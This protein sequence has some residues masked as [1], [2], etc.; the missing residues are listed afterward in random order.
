MKLPLREHAKRRIP[1]LLMLLLLLP[2]AATGVADRVIGYSGLGSL[3]QSNR[4]WLEE[5]F[6]RSLHLFGVLSAVK[7]TLAIVEGSEVGVGFGIEVGDVVQA[8]YDHV[9]I[10]WRTVLAAGVMLKSLQFLLD[11]VDWL[12]QWLLLAALSFITLMLILRWYLGSATWPRRMA[13][14]GALV[15]TVMVVTLYL[16]LPFSIAGGRML[17]EKITAPSLAEAE[18]GIQE[19]SYQIQNLNDKQGGLIGMLEDGKRK[20]EYLGR[21][22]QRKT[23]ELMVYLFTIIAAYLFDCVLFPIIL[24]VLLFYA[25]RV[26]TGYLFDI[27][28]Q[29]NLKEDIGEVMAR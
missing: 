5:A 18:K 29:H 3:H 25:T 24:F 13:R 11:A 9:D 10:A 22:I 7:V 26:T 2:L 21:F 17:S 28:R 14:D 15:T 1:I 8:T 6:D 23:R 27:R 16:V 4:V 12:D 20:V 19:I